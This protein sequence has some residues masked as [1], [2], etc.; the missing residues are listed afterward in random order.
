[1]MRLGNRPSCA[2]A[3]ATV[4]SLTGASAS[5]WAQPLPGTGGSAGAVVPCSLAGINPA[6]HPGVFGDP[7][8]ARQYGFFQTKDGTWHVKKNCRTNR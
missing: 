6:Y 2:I 7:N 4:L 8:V 5:A 1:M 3:L